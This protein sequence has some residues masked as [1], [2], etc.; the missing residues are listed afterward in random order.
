MFKLIGK[1]WKLGNS[2]VIT[3]PKEKAEYEG[4]EVGSDVYAII[5]KE[6]EEI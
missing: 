6:N 4:L 3:I 5:R 1:V 2:L